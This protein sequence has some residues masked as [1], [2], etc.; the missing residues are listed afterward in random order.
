MADGFSPGADAVLRYATRI[1]R[2][3]LATAR[4]LEDD[5]AAVVMEFDERLKA[6]DAADD[7]RS[8]IRLRSLRENV[9]NYRESLR[10]SVVGS[11]DEAINVTI[12]T[13]AP[14]LAEA[15]FISSVPPVQLLSRIGEKSFDGRTWQRWGVK[16]ADD[17][18]DRVE[19]DLRRGFAA[20]EPITETRKRLQKSL[21]LSKTAAQRLATT[22]MN[23]ISNASRIE[24]VQQLAA[25]VV[26][27]WRFVSVLDGRT[28]K[29]CAGLDGRIFQLKD[30]NLPRPPRHPYC[31]S[32]LVP[33]T[34]ASAAGNPQRAS[35]DGPVSSRLDFEGWLKRQPD[36]F[37]REYLGP[38]RYGAFERGLPLGNMATADRPLSVA[39]LRR[40]YPSKFAA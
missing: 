37:Q 1:E 16:L 12:E 30:P 29:I 32:Q 2:L 7:S 19:S 8:A 20:S 21:N 31:R 25:D 22:A 40:M 38:E 14:A 28:S 26:R 27:G 15:G 10:S 17:M 11:V 3:S 35:K 34:A 39:E 4:K 23:D 33:E 13:T 24:V 5:L 18:L 9:A 6:I 36:G